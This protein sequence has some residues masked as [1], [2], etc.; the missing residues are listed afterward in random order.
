MKLMKRDQIWSYKFYIKY[1]EKK[2]YYSIYCDKWNIKPYQWF[3]SDDYLDWLYLYHH[4][5]SE[6]IEEI[7]SGN[8]WNLYYN[9]K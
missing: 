4:L 1:N 3:T 7:F 9:Q 5:Q 6:M 2:R 8:D